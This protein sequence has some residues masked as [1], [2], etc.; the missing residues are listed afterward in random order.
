V[1]Y[2]QITTIAELRDGL[3]FPERHPFRGDTVHFAD[4][5][6]AT[7]STNTSS[8]KRK[9]SSDTT[10]DNASGPKRRRSNSQKSRLATESNDQLSIGKA[11]PSL[12]APGEDPWENRIYSC[13]L[14][15]PAGRVISEFRTIKE[16]LE[17]MRDAI[18]HTSL[19]TLLAT[20]FIATSRQTTLSLQSPRLRMASRACSSILTWRK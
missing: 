13:L 17:S 5:P 11:R 18:R 14:V 10:S 6:S 4:P 7:G 15:L 20:F 1:A 12:Y 9:S 3:E 2:R 8:H 19:C 16:L